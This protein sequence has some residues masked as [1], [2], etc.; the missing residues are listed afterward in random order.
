MHIKCSVSFF[1][2]VDHLKKPTTTNNLVLEFV[3]SFL[4]W[5]RLSW[6]GHG[7]R[8][9]QGRVRKLVG[10]WHIGCLFE[11]EQNLPGLWA[12][13]LIFFLFYSH[14]SPKM[15]KNQRLPRKNNIVIHTK[16]FFTE[17]TLI[18]WMFFHSWIITF[19]G[20]DRHGMIKRDLVII[21]V[22]AVKVLEIR[23]K[24]ML[25]KLHKMS[26]RFVIIRNEL[27]IIRTKERKT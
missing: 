7:C 2:C 20:Y 25:R 1:F 11:V 4:I 6:R 13:G 23:R 27:V 3:W 15:S 10:L 24:H 8:I 5:G 22:K 19:S 16:N 21:W 18:D 14:S 26:C 17:I 9:F 12:M